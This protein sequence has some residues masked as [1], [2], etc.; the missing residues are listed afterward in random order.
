MRI[1]SIAFLQQHGSEAFLNR[2][3]PDLFTN[4]QQYHNQI[5]ELVEQ[6]KKTNEKI[7]GGYYEAIMNRPNRKNIIE[8]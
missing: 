7:L 3:F 5:K 6:G 8:K 4:K 1:K 2:S